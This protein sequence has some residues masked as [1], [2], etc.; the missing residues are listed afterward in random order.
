MVRSGFRGCWLA[1]VGG[2][3]L[4]APGPRRPLSAAPSSVLWCPPVAG[5]LQAP[6]HHR[7][8]AGWEGPPS[9]RARGLHCNC[10]HPCSSTTTSTNIDHRN[11][12]ELPQL[13][14]MPSSC[15][16]QGSIYMYVHLYVGLDVCIHEATRAQDAKFPYAERHRDVV[17]PLAWG[18]GQ[19]KLENPPV[20]CRRWA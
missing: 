5:P 17:I 6:P 10:H 16:G 8:L 7:R 18:R 12:P 4:E 3:G 19:F 11:Q 15:V 9:R 13:R 1:V 14:G 20:W 2:W